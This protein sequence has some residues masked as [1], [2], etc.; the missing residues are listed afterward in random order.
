MHRRRAPRP[1]AEA[2]GPALE[3]SQPQTTLASVQRIWGD[4]VGEAIARE[5]QPVAERD[6]V[7]TVRC[8]SATWAAELDLMQD[9]LRGRLE[10][11]LGPGIVS[12]LRL[13]ANAEK[14]R[15]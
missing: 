9:E 7:V 12:G 2:L 3:R 4:S 1:L 8:S 15:P 6:G 11:R 13:V 14:G 10:R 5:A